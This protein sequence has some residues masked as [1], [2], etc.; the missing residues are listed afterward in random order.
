MNLTPDEEATLDGEK[1]PGYQK[2][3]EIIVAL[4]KIY[5]AD[6]LVAI[7]SAQVSGVS[8]Q[9]IG[10]AGLEFLEEWASMGATCSVQATLNP[11][12]VDL[13]SW[14]EFGFPEDIA[15]KQLRIIDAYVKMGIQPTC[16]CVPYLIGN[17]PQ[18]GNHVAW[19]ES[20]AI[21]YCNSI[22]GARTNREGGPSSLAAGLVG[23][24]ANYGL[25]LTE[26]RK[27]EL[28]IQV[29][30]P[31]KSG[32]DFGALGYFV[33][34][35]GGNKVIYFQ[36]IRR[37]T[38]EDLK[39]FGASLATYGSIALYHIEGFTPEASIV[40]PVSKTVIVT[41]DDLKQAY[42]EINSPLARVD[43]VALGCP[44]NSLE[45]MKAIGQSLQG[46]SLKSELWVLTARP[47]KEAAEHLGL[48]KPILAAGGK[49]IADT[50]MVVA[51]IKEFGFH[52][53]VTNSAKACFYSQN[54]HNLQVRLASL[55]KCIDVAVSGIWS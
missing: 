24:T 47:I 35:R 22:I 42:G 30:C 26:N 20:S 54:L 29:E 40:S 4:G 31:L 23:K 28:T 18:F 36:G 7:W 6:N 14:K 13:R 8:Y 15:R 44:H 12:A 27:P 45:E 55:E 49:I 2:A 50:C 11:A 39:L 1:G 25:H 16:T 9:N 32:A 41:E 43:F 34:K 3:M 5:E 38:L 33:G 46:K 17:L 52:T 19:G 37:A 21:A 10:D 53:I 51:P 48:D